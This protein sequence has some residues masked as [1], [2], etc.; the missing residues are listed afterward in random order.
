MTDLPPEAHKLFLLGRERLELTGV[1]EVCAFDEETLSLATTLGRLTVKG[2]RMKISVFHRET[3][4]F[5]AEGKFHAFA[6]SSKQQ[7]GGRI[8]RLFR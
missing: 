2:E 4:D 3:G 1:Q 6:Y 5:C 8:A 7:K